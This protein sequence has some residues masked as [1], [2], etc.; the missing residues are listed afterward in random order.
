MVEMWCGG[1]RFRQE[2]TGSRPATPPRE[3]AAPAAGSG[4][5][6]EFTLDAGYFGPGAALTRQ[7]GPLDTRAPDCAEA[8]GPGRVVVRDL[9]DGRRR[10][11]DFVK[12]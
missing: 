5:R 9:R 7:R 12:I 10:A 11:G 1:R 4:T 2:L 6:W 8:A 3:W